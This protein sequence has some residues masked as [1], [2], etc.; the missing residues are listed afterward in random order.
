MKLSEAIRLGAML[1]PQGFGQY[2]ANDA[3]CAVGAAMDGAGDSAFVAWQ[4]LERFLDNRCPVCLCLVL[5]ETG[6][7]RNILPHLNDDHRWTREQI[8]D[9][10]A[11]IEPPETPP[12]IERTPDDVYAVARTDG[13]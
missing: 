1:K 13:T 3:T 7:G 12:T 8:A 2:R 6:R 11:T 4:E 9:W 10:V 5:T